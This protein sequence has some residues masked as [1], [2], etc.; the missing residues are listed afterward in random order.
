MRCVRML[1]GLAA[2][3]GSLS[4]CTDHHPSQCRLQYA[5]WSMGS[6]YPD[7][8]DGP[9][10]LEIPWLY[11]AVFAGS[12]DE[13]GG[14]N[15]SEYKLL[16]F[17]LRDENKAVLLEDCI[18]LEVKNFRIDAVWETDGDAQS[19]ENQPTSVSFDFVDVDEGTILKTVS[20]PLELLNPENDPQQ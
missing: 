12:Q 14:R 1:T 10:R 9:G 6:F 16:Q 11:E 19:V 17:Q 13:T 20:Y 15:N 2:V 7:R 4:G 8:P 3:L 18:H 5:S